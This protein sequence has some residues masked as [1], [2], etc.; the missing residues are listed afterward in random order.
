[1]LISV[2]LSDSVS[3]AFIRGR[4]SVW[5]TC[6][7][8][9]EQYHI[10]PKASSTKTEMMQQ[11]GENNPLSSLSFSLYLHLLLAHL[12]LLGYIS[13]SVLQPQDLQHPS[14]P[15]LCTTSLS[16]SLH[17]ILCIPQPVGVFVG[18]QNVSTNNLQCK[19]SFCLASHL[20]YLFIF[21]ERLKWW[22]I[23]WINII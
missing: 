6:L 19:Q 15:Y 22:C 3:L 20:I 14:L 8:R 1:M 21:H 7:S 11:L 5:L 13:L 10:R 9:G 2:S 4:L 12:Q 17:L 23:L 16:N 18:G